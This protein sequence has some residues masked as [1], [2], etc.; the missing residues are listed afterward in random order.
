M[1]RN[2]ALLVSLLIPSL[3]YA[4][5]LCGDTV[6]G[7][8][9][10]DFQSLCSAPDQDRDGWHQSVDCDDTDRDVYPGAWKAFLVASPPC[11]NMEL[12]QCQ[13]DG[14]WGTCYDLTALPANIVD[15]G[16]NLFWISQTE[17]GTPDGSLA[18]P[19]RWDFFSNPSYAHYRSPQPGDVYLLTG[20]DITGT[21]S[22]GGTTRQIYVDNKDGTPTNPIYVLNPLGVEIVGAGSDPNVVEPYR[23]QLSDYWVHYGIKVDGN[24]STAGI[25]IS[26]ATGA[27]VYGSVVH[28][29][30]GE[31]NNNLSGV[32]VTV[33]DSPTVFNNVAYDNY[34]RSNPNGI[35][36]AQFYVDEVTNSRTYNNIA[37][38][39]GT[40]RSH[41]Y[42]DKH[43]WLAGESQDNEFF[44][45]IGYNCLV[46]GFFL[47]DANFQIYNNYFRD[48]G[49]TASPNRKMAIQYVQ[50]GNGYFAGTSIFNNTVDG[51]AFLEFNPNVGT[52][53]NPALDVHDNVIVDTA[54]S[55][56]SDG[57]NGFVRVCRYCDNTTCPTIV[58]DGAFAIDDNCY[59]NTAST[60][61]RFVL[62]PDACGASYSSF[63][64]WQG[65]GWDVGTS[66]E[67]PVINSNGE[68]SSINC[69]GKGFILGGV[70]PPSPTPTPTPGPG[71]GSN[72]YLPYY[73]G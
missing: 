19:Y 11:G 10:P 8:V 44:G 9:A 23:F 45:N 53:E 28:D 50:D 1:F 57:E 22:D 27:T 42:K 38:T 32:K 52:L 29:V 61:M 67:N 20:A 72:A 71:D 16:L 60:A 31:Q 30:D 39:N 12:A 15:G 14:S 5:D 66:N 21:W 55:Y 13:P 37:F 70:T 46:S 48:I 17:G 65:A 64:P 3:T 54:T 7:A 26:G 24:F 25:Y 34:D 4:V 6:P 63:P 47:V 41:C 18:N 49:G 56:Q 2:L 62:Y 69:T 43:R 58:T 40:A 51:A 35:N 68:A 59:Y 36:N 33:I 73:D